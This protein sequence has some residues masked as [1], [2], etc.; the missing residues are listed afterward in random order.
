MTPNNNS[1]FYTRP[2]F[3]RIFMAACFLVALGIR[4]YDLNDLPLDFHPARQLQSMLKVRGMFLDNNAPAQTPPWQ[5][6]MAVSQW[7]IQPIEEPEIVER[8]ALWAY[9]AAG[10]ANLWFPRFFSI[11]FWLVGGIG[12]FLLIS[13][14]VGKDGAVVGTLFYLFLPYAVS[15]SRAFM[16]DPLMIMFIIWGIWALNRWHIRPS[17]G[18]AILAGGLCAMAIL[19]KLTAIFIIAGAIFGLELGERGFKK[20]L[21]NPQLWVL[22]ILSLLPAAI[23]NFVGI[24]VAG[25]I[26]QGSVGGR[27]LLNLVVDPLSYIRWDNKVEEVLGIT[28]LLLAIAGTFLLKDRRGRSLMLGLW[29]GYVLFG[30]FFMYYYG[31]HDYYHLPL[32]PIVA[33]GLAAVGQA[34]IQALHG[35]S[36]GKLS[37]FVIVGLLLL[38]VG[39]NTWAVR[40]TLKRTDY[41]PDAIFWQTLGNKL[42]GYNVLAL[43][44]D[45]NGRLSY[46][47]WFDAAYYPSLGDFQHQA[48][49]GST[50]DPLQYFKN[51]SA[52]KDLF[53]DTMLDELDAQPQFKALLYATYPVFDQGKGYVIFDLRK[54]K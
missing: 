32:I 26:S 23:Y 40:N 1:I 25:F 11:L 6:Q 46:W 9:Q 22:G 33:I 21:R 18:A 44:Q 2:W 31:T 8:L 43:T 16:P 48:T 45:Y 39:Q 3:L 13:D 5:R 38:A 30:V 17:W 7:K 42:R 10:T 50:E 53:L 24:Y 27:I 49:A 28:A 52:G 29:S 12:L 36:P 51:A 15:A 14:L 4:I 47:G 37:N 35:I 20:S 54:A 34:V 41:R 19:V